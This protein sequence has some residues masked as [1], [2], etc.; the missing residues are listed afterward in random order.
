M[1]NKGMVYLVGAG[2]G[3]PG[4]ITEKGRKLLESCDV[5]IYDRLVSPKLISYTKPNCEKVYVG[6]EVGHHAIKQEEINQIIIEKAQSATVVVRL[7]G[8]DPY[9]FGRGGEEVLSLK[10][11][12]IDYEVI[13]GV[14]S[15]IAAATYAGIPITHR[16]ASQ[17]F[18]VITGHTAQEDT[19]VPEDINSLAKLN[20]TLVI[21]MGI[22]NLKLIRDELLENGRTKDTPV[23]VIENATTVWQREVRGTLEDIC[24]RVESAG[25]KAPA[26]IIIGNVAGLDL[27]SERK[28]TLAGVRIG[29]TGTKA[30]TDKLSERLME[31]DAL[32]EPISTSMITEYSNNEAFETALASLDQYQ[33][34]VFTSTNSVQIFFNKMIE[35]HIDYRRLAHIKFAVVGPGTGQA[36]QKHG[37]QA[38]FTPEQ[39][40]VI[41]LAKQLSSQVTVGEKLLIP[42][43][44]QGS[45]ELVNILNAQQISFNDIKIYDIKESFEYPKE[46]LAKLSDFDYLIFSSSSGVHGFLKT[47][48][49]NLK[50]LLTNTQ[51]VCIGEATESTLKDY[52]F[53]DI[54]V[55]KESSVAG[56][57]ERIC[58]D[59]NN[60]K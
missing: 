39:Y 14:T 47:M 23:A 16:G 36:L 12:G 21:L 43:A 52:G 32:V 24:Q 27:R 7:K 15:S 4:L 50:E 49:E 51:I 13:P 40:T 28:G 6:K 10:E 38:D 42:R 44:Q 35:L 48:P 31:L 17:S 59:Q 2:P 1:D 37:F 56:L 46:W 33:W 11:Q 9:V 60:K 30:I 25:I 18:H 34:I 20:G 41:C 45:E 57:M 54:L 3:D 5:V 26:V 58:E 19:T 29:I 22:G 8:G 55:A 53:K